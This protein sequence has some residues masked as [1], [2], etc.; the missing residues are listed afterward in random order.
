VQIYSLNL[1]S[2]FFDKNTEEKLFQIL[3]EDEKQRI[4]RITSANLRKKFL[5]GRF[6][7]KSQL[8]KVLDLHPSQITLQTTSNGRPELNFPNNSAKIISFNLSHSQ[9]LL[10][11]AISNNQVGIDVEFIKNRNFLQ[12][13]EFF[14]DPDEVKALNEINSSGR[15]EFFYRLW[16]QKES[17]IK[18][19]DDKIINLRSKKI[20]KL[21][22]NNYH[23]I[24]LTSLSNYVISVTEK[25]TENQ[26]FQTTNP[27]L[28]AVENFD[29]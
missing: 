7:I 9:D 24:T 12:I 2:V 17:F 20:A 13:A 14:F 5:C 28:V 19:N 15:A 16:T 1:S 27:K 23:S 8:G 18:C 3:A 21:L 29:F 22:D 6:L 25:I 26:P 10:A 11:L 4:D